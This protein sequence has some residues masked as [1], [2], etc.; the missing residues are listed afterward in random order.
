VLE[1]VGREIVPTVSVPET[2]FGG[3]DATVGGM[4]IGDVKE[5]MGELKEPVI[6]LMLGRWGDEVM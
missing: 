2:V 1:V 4:G 6:P 5:G 3:C